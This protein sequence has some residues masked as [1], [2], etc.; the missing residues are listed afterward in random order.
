V[1]QDAPPFAQTLGGLQ[2]QMAG[3]GY[4]LEVV[5]LGNDAS[6]PATLSAAMSRVRPQ[7]VVALGAAALQLASSWAA[8]VPIVAGLVLEPAE[9][10]LPNV[11]GVYLQYPAAVEL[12]W[13]RK[14]VPSVRRVGIV[15]HSTA[16]HARVEE[17]RQA[18][19]GLGLTIQAIRIQGPEQLP[20]ALAGVAG[21]SDVLWGLVD[22]VVFNPGTVKPLM[23]F[24][25]KHLVPLYG[26]SGAWVR[27]GAL[28]AIE[29]DYGDIGVQCGELLER[30]LS[31]TPVSAIEPVPPRR[32]RYA[33]N[34]R[35]AELLRRTVREALVREGEIY[36]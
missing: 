16:S 9:L 29:R 13:L 4:T 25:F 30:L 7:A 35:S 5:R 36:R 21:R 19:A 10:R 8:T 18:A 12:E 34:L 11:T 32:V 24:S 2:K 26:P 1:S 20:D 17:A 14:L 3:K 23:V 22:P 15:Y 28:A 27:G 31:G 6:D 33:V